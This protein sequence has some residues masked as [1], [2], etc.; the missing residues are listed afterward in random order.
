V[1]SSPIAV[2][3]NAS[4][5][6]ALDRWMIQSRTATTASAARLTELMT[7]TVMTSAC[8]FPP[9]VWRRNRT[10]NTVLGARVTIRP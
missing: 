9:V 3:A 6:A 5:T 10:L 1:T 7:P 4:H 8:T 2:N